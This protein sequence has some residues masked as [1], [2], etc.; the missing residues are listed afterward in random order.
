MVHYTLGVEMHS[1]NRIMLCKIHHKVCRLLQYTCRVQFIRY[2]IRS[3][4]WITPTDSEPHGRGLLYKAGRQAS[5]HSVTVRL[6][7]RMG[8]T[9]D[10]SDF[11]LG[12]I[13]GARHV[14]STILETAGPP[15]LF[16][17]SSV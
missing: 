5:R 3:Q 8:K 17:H 13:I 7:L 4:K 16:T 9:S 6:N 12:M 1:G 15:G 14:G 2:T 10:L 11:E